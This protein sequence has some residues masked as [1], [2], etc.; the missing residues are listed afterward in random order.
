M[1]RD[2]VVGAVGDART[3]AGEAA[4][5]LRCPAKSGIYSHEQEDVELP[6]PYLG[7][8]RADEAA[9]EFYR[10]QPASY[11]KAANWWVASG[12]QE[13]T[14]LA[15]LEKLIACSARGERVPQFTW[16]KARPGESGR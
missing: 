15:R 14:R 6:E 11:R 2:G 3:A 4:F 8:L 5:A 13:K 9:W 10:D 1:S 16:R 12:K 7:T